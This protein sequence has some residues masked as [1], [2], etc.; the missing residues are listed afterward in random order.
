MK[1]LKSKTP[2]LILLAI[3]FFIALTD[4]FVWS[5]KVDPMVIEVDTAEETMSSTP[6]SFLNFALT[7]GEE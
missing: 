3:F 2:Y 7:N 6:N 4:T 5:E 1:V